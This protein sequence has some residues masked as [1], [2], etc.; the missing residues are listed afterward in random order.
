MVSYRKRYGFVVLSGVGRKVGKIKNIE[1]I[2]KGFGAK[3]CNKS[4]T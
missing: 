1:V 3:K 4:V 2:K